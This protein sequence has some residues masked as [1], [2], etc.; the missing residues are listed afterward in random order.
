MRVEAVM[1]PLSQA[2]ILSMEDNVRVALERMTRDRLG[3]ACI[4][5]SDGKLQAVLTDGDVRRTLLRSQKPVSALL[6]DEASKHATSNVLTVSRNT[7]LRDA[8]SKMGEL[9]IW[10][11][12]VVEPDDTLVGVLHLHPAVQEL[13]RQASD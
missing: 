6:A 9:G 4:V 5:D 3:L 2:P 13:L 1:I 10:D 11:L 8:V 12:P 7:E